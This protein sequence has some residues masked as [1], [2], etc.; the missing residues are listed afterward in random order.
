[1]KEQKITLMD[2]Q[3]GL[4]YYST[5]YQD[6]IKL[7]VKKTDKPDEPDKQP[8]DV[9][10]QT[11]ILY[12]GIKYY[13]TIIQMMKDENQKRSICKDLV[14]SINRSLYCLFDNEE[15]TEEMISCETSK[16]ILT[17]KMEMYAY[18]EYLQWISNSFMKEMNIPNRNCLIFKFSLALIEN[19]VQMNTLFTEKYNVSGVEKESPALCI[20]FSPSEELSNV[21]KYL[22]MLTHEVSHHFLYIERKT[23][24]EF[25][26]KYLLDNISINIVESMFQVV[27]DSYA[28][29][30]RG[31]AEKILAQSVS[32]VLNKGFREKF[33]DFLENGHLIDLEGHLHTYF[34]ELVGKQE[35]T[36]G[37]YD[38]GHSFFM[39]LKEAFFGLSSMTD[40]KWY[41][42]DKGRKYTSKDIF[43]SMFFDVLFEKNLEDIEEYY[44][45]IEYVSEQFYKDEIDKIIKLNPK[46]AKIISIPRS[47]V[48]IALRLLMPKVVAYAKGNFFDFRKKG[49][50]HDSVPD[51]LEKLSD[52]YNLLVSELK[53]FYKENVKKGFEQDYYAFFDICITAKSYINNIQYICREADETIEKKELKYPDIQ[54]IYKKLN[55]DVKEALE[56]KEDCNSEEKMFFSS[57]KVHS[58]LI[59]LGL[60]CDAENADNFIKIFLGLFNDWDMNRFDGMTGEYLK[61]YREVFADLSMCAAFQFNQL[62]Y[63]NYIVD[64]FSYELEPLNR[65]ERNMIVDR[66]R[67]VFAALSNSCMHNTVKNDSEVIEK[68]NSYMIKEKDL[69]KNRWRRVLLKCF[70]EK[71]D[72]IEHDKHFCNVYSDKIQNASWIKT[73]QKNT[74][75]REIGKYYNELYSG[76]STDD[77]VKRTFFEEF[78]GKYENRCREYQ[79]GEVDSIE[80]ML[81]G[82]E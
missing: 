77:N 67:L 47:S 38:T 78:Y 9:D 76:K 21:Y 10:A 44:Q 3:R 26:L 5:R 24:N 45:Q 18:Q 79:E 72:N 46:D 53:K 35:R 57:H 50:R 19:K 27:S 75:I 16:Y 73:C 20:V 43:L 68:I 37:I 22:P 30:L 8:V 70:S 14:E 25:I 80:I 64:R 82:D 71:Q 7:L 6:L 69:T 54:N 58:V 2:I 52:D 28:N 81:R 29:I 49:V 61:L 31:E 42:T 39:V 33:P 17:S 15:S 12:K 66:V 62:G 60:L 23:R 74:V 59:K 63:F 11:M 34:Y 55:M 36:K 13:C 32:K 40:M 41:V 65:T 4:P 56:Q 48:G 51:I 1:M